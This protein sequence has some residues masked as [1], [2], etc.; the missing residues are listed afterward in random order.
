MT[1]TPRLIQGGRSPAAHPSVNT[2]ATA[3]LELV[4]PPEPQ[5]RAILTDVSTPRVLTLT[6]VAGKGLATPAP[7]RSGEAEV[8][9]IATILGPGMFPWPEAWPSARLRASMSIQVRL[10]TRRSAP[11]RDAG[12]QTGSARD[13][14]RWR[15]SILIWR[16]RW[17]APTTPSAQA[18]DRSARA[19]SALS[20]PRRRRV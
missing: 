11:A 16:I 15:P 4:R 14:P 5:V 18:E 19:T 3:V 17:D 8:P 1:W 9:I 12:R 7:L 13:I 20:N 6:D 10:P 2:E